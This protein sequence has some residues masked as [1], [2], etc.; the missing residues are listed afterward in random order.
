MRGKKV[1]Y[2]IAMSL[3]AIVIF[4]FG[5]MAMN[6]LCISN[7]TGVHDPQWVEKSDQLCQIFTGLAQLIKQV[8]NS[9]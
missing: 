5:T 3:L 1:L 7:Q 9:I 4:Y 8:T 6:Q 2:A